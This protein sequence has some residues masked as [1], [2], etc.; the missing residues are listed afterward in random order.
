MKDVDALIKD[1]DRADSADS[2][3][4]AVKAL[5]EKRS[6]V[7]IPHLIQVLNFNNPGA[8]V[9]A[10]EGL[11]QIGV[12]AVPS[13]LEQLDRHNYTARSWAIRA[14]AG[15]GD[16]RGLVTLLGAATADFAVSVRR[17]S[18]RGL[19]LMKWYWF[20]S[21]LRE[22]AQAE[23]LEALLFVLEQD[24]EWIVRYSAV[25]GL[26][27]LLQ[28]YAQATDRVEAAWQ[29]ILDHDPVPAVRA[30]VAYA[31]QNL[32]RLTPPEPEP[33]PFP[34]DWQ[35]ILTRLRERKSLERR[36]ISDPNN[37]RDIAKAIVCQDL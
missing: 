13:L 27:G 3:L 29:K 21:N 28:S 34:I 32:P 8:A 6:V 9:A 5:G 11:V 22:I 23:A 35:E 10:V 25:T 15:I 2:L 24:E 7:A 19:G 16:P 1:L 26:Q 37:Y 18:A 36:T 17:A 33:M 30:R 31:R 4:N 20:P 12:E 14:L